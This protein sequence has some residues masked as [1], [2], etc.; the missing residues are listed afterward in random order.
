ME[1]CSP[2]PAFTLNDTDLVKEVVTP[3]YPDPYN[4]DRL[5]ELVITVDVSKPFSVTL[6]RYVE[7]CSTP[8]FSAYSKTST[9]PLKKTSTC[10]SSNGRNQLTTTFRYTGSKKNV[11]KVE[12]LLYLSKSSGNGFSILVSGK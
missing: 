3:G 12:I 8:P 2:S 5:C 11:Q 9:T 1:F 7:C 6:V 10:S 4:T